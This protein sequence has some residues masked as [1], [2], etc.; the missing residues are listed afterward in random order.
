M[1]INNRLS[2]LESAANIEGVCACRHIP[3]TELRMDL[4]DEKCV[5]FSVPEVCPDCYKQIIK[6]ILTLVD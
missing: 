6:N 3:K 4:S 2:K 1:N 5:C